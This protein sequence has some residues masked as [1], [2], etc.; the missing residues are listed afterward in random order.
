MRECLTNHHRRIQN[1]GKGGILSR[2]DYKIQYVKGKLNKVADALSRYF[3][4]DTWFDVYPPSTYV[5]A[6]VRIDK[7]LDDIPSDRQREIKT[8]SIEFHAIRMINTLEA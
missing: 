4:S 1:V 2:F 7:D 6:D 3:E 5:N 8:K